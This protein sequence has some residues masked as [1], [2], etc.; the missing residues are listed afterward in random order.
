[1]YSNMAWAASIALLL[2]GLVTGPLLIL[3]LLLSAPPDLGSLATTYR[4]FALLLGGLASLVPITVVAL[5]QARSTPR[6][7]RASLLLLGLPVLLMAA[8]AAWAA[9]RV[10]G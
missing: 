2:V 9:L 6:W 7:F 3:T 4:L 1:V 10:W 8:G 5:A